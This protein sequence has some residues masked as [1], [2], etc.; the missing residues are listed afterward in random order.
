MKKHFLLFFAI[1][2]PLINMAQ[3]TTSQQE[4]LTRMKTVNN[5][6][7]A[8]LGPLVDVNG[9]SINFSEFEGK[10]LVLD[11]WASWCGPCIQQT[12]YFEALAEKFGD[13]EVEFVKISIDDRQEYW[14]DYVTKRN[15]TTNS[16]WIG[17]DES[18]PIYPFVYYNYK[19]KDF[20]GVVIAVP[21]YVII[22]KEGKILNNQAYNPSHPRLEKEI[23]KYLKN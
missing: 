11:F 17:T 14:G 1:L 22:S 6:E 8:P 23:Q 12:P 18:N 5:G 9:N 21:R 13:Q 20:E 15:W 19:E 10:L 16:Y 2:F 7:K 4:K 3:S